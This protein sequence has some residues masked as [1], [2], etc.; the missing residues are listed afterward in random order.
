MAHEFLCSLSICE[1][2]LLHWKP[3]Q[4]LMLR[5]GYKKAYVRPRAMTQ[6]LQGLAALV[7]DVSSI[8]GG[9]HIR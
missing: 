5:L 1:R 9:S 2:P 4:V 6:R 7:G 8:P 3:C